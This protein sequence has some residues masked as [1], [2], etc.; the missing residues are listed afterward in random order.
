MRH[1]PNPLFL[2]VL[3]ATGWA[4]PSGTAAQETNP[5]R[6]GEWRVY[7]GTPD[8][9]RF[10]PLDEI[11]AGNVG[12]LEVAWRWSAADFGPSP[13]VRNAST[14]LMVDGVLYV[15]AGSRRAVV[16]LDPG[17]G[18]EIWRWE[19]AEEERLEDAP[20][21]NSGRGVTYW[22]DGAG[23]ARILVVTPGFQMVALDARTGR[24]VSTFGEAGTVDLMDDHRAR[25][26]VPLLGS[27]G[28]SSPAVVVDGVIVVGSAQHVGFFPPSRANTPGDVRGYDV[29]TGELLWTFHTIPEVGEQGRETWAD[30]SADFTGNAG[31]WAAISYDEELGYVYLPT[32]AATGDFYG[33]HRPGDN[34]YSTSLVALEARTGRRVWHFQTVHHDIWDWDN[35]TAP[36]LADVTV[37]GVPRRV[38]AQ[39]S[40]QGFVYVFDRVTGE[41]IWPIPET[42][43]PQ[44]DTPGE[45]TAPTQ[46]IPSRPAPFER[47]G[48]T[49]DDLIDFTP[50]I[51]ARADEIAR[52]FRWGPL[53]TPPSV[54]DAADGTSGT[55]MM[56]STTG[57]A[58]WE[59]AALDPTTGILY[60]PSVTSPSVYSLRAGG[61]RSDMDFMA[62][63][64]RASLAPGV[65]IVKPPWGRITA[66]D[67][68]S[69]DHRWMVANGDT[70]AEVAERLELDPALLPRTGKPI[71]GGLLVTATLLFSGEGLGGEP[72]LRALD[73]ATG[74]TVAEVPLPASA[75]GHPVTYRNEGRQ[76]IVVAVG[77]SSHPAEFVALRLPSS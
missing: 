70:P 56:P 48:F 43:V 7:G 47:Q 8:H 74:E 44:S 69:G 52:R 50:E 63:G 25:D 40:K 26:G 68:N 36:I 29:R 3:A 1:G 6:D 28:A 42:P 58:N 66:I 15:T 49:A 4:S 13:E 62:G 31:V 57:G 14:P 17:D 22:T 51:R 37:D 35:P 64:G 75:T 33:G 53:F 39:V 30:D 2:L 12:D 55:L 45:Y 23:D 10:S 77:S 67:L 71:R 16:A 65:P 24:P 60:I 76:Y 59:A 21:V 72:I 27:I 46:P 73:K 61:D 20:R 18:R 54:T 38:V 19:P 5:G 32:E 41:P 11:D 9:A 34:L